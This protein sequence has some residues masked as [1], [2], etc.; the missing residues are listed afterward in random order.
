MNLEPKKSANGVRMVSNK[1]T[2]H[3]S[4]FGL[5]IRGFFFQNWASFKYREPVG[6][7]YLLVGGHGRENYI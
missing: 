3:T 6:F 2:Y 4:T 7:F 5:F 1:L